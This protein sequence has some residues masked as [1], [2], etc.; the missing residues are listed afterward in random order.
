M[1]FG[2]GFESMRTISV[3]STSTTPTKCI[4]PI[5]ISGPGPMFEIPGARGRII[6]LPMQGPA[7]QAAVARGRSTRCTRNVQRTS[8]VRASFLSP[9][10]SRGG[11]GL[12]KTLLRAIRIEDLWTPFFSL[13]HDTG[14]LEFLNQG[15]LSPI[16]LMS[17]IC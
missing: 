2:N 10:M 1:I 6:L 11:E 3:R 14:I 12:R 13:V 8:I 4:P 15:F 7:V 5:A 16:N 9:Q 17:G